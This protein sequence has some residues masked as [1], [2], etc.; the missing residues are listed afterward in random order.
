M[1]LI[2]AENF[3]LWKQK[4]LLKGGDYKS[5]DLLIDSLGGLSN[6]EQLIK[7]KQQTLDS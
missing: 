4:Q 1:Y 2:S 7:W 5:L 6:K 3:S